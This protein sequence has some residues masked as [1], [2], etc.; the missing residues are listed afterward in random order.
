MNEGRIS[1]TIKN[2]EYAIISK[3]IE[4]LLA[5][6]LRTIF[7]RCLSTV[8]LGLNGVFTNILTVLSLMDLG[9][10]SAIAFSLYRPLADGNRPKTVALM[11]LYRKFYRN[12]GILICV[13]G[14]CLTPFLE[15]II[16]LPEEVS[17]IYI[18]YWLNIGN[19]A[20]SYFFAYK[21][22]L[23]IAD[24]KLYINYNKLYMSF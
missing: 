19:T 23:I 11:D 2:S 22:T 18:I 16:T 20:F 14:F 9:L 1:K 13:I 3:L 8:Y 4:T 5:F 21:R 24:Q 17:N 6:F 12:I 10:G 15:L 7:I